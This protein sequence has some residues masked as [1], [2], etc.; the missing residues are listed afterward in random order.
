MRYT[1]E[2]GLTDEPRALGEQLRLEA[3]ERFAQGH[4][5]P[6]IAHDLQVSVRPVQRSRRAWSQSGTAALASKGPASLPLLSD[7]LFA[8]LK[9]EPAMGHKMRLHTAEGR[10]EVWSPLALSLPSAAGMPSTERDLTVAQFTARSL[11]CWKTSERSVS[12][13]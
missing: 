1:Q 11:V 7:E 3:A 6:A 5:N 4:Q 10:A 9:H 8:V 2:G 12:S 13:A